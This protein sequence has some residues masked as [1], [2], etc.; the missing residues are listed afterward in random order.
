MKPMTAMH[1]RVSQHA[2]LIQEGDDALPK[3]SNFFHKRDRSFELGS[4]KR[5]QIVTAQASPARG[6][7]SK[8]TTGRGT[9]ES[10]KVGTSSRMSKRDP[11]G[12]TKQPS[13]WTLA[14]ALRRVVRDRVQANVVIA[15]IESVERIQTADGVVAF[16][17]A[18]TLIVVR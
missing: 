16:E 12:V 13:K 11:R 1:S 18:D 2:E 7:G 6:G 9:S 14:C 5:R 8:R 4:M 10:T 17:N 15:T 3:K